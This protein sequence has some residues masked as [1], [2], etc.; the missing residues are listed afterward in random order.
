M[1]R[2]YIYKLTRSA[3]QN[4]ATMKAKPG[5]GQFVELEAQREECAGRLNAALTIAG[6]RHMDRQKRHGSGM[7]ARGFIFAPINSQ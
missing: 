6:R 5:R 1:P 2:K 7:T 3:G 4:K